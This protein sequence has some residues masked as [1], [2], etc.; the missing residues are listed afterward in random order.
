MTA[1][2]I[3]VD[4]RLRDALNAE[5]RKRGQTAGSF[6]EHLLEMWLREQRFAAMRE[7]LAAASAVDLDSYA[8]ETADFDQ[9]DVS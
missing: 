8:A 3:K 9:L 6:L 1:T 4:S 2:T 7:A 5:A